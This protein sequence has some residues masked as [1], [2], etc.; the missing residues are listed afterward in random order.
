MNFKVTQNGHITTLTYRG[1]F[2]GRVVR[3]NPACYS[4]TDAY[5]EGRTFLVGNPGVARAALLSWCRRV[6]AEV[7]AYQAGQPTVEYV[8][9]ILDKAVLVRHGK[10][11]RV[12]P[13][14]FKPSG[15]RV[16]FEDGYEVNTKIPKLTLRPGISKRIDAY[17]S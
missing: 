15:Y 3:N 1:V 9:A 11:V 16:T 7:R 6:F 5:G 14:A 12:Q 17:L 2:L 13:A 10:A 4:V 8:N